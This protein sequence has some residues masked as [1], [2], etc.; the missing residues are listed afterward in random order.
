MSPQKS[1][2]RIR[3]MRNGRMSSGNGIRVASLGKSPRRATH[4][5]T[6]DQTTMRI[7][8]N[9]DFKMRLSFFGVPGG[10]TP[11]SSRGN[12]PTRLPPAKSET[13]FA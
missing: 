7:L 2:T 8:L 4:P 10:N 13:K 9:I 5:K 3:R 11:G 6:N 1:E 12:L